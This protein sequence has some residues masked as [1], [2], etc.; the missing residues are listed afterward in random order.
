MLIYG[1]N[2]KLMKIMINNDNNKGSH[3]CVR[4]LPCFALVCL[5]GEGNVVRRPAKPVK[6]DEEHHQPGAT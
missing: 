4:A 6:K 3:T 1:N 5:A 2:N